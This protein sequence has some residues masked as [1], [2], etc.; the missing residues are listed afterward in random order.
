M[1]PLARF[2]IK[3]LDR[4]F[5]WSASEAWKRWRFWALNVVT[6]H[7]VVELRISV[8]AGGEAWKVHDYALG[9]WPRG[10][11]SLIPRDRGTD[12]RAPTLVSLGQ[13][14][15]TC[16]PDSLTALFDRIAGCRA[17][18]EVPGSGCY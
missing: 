3:G 6:A 8:I 11:S 13:A 15:T 16:P 10:G 14:D 2:R 9:G 18:L 5:A 7:T 1:V 4:S 17:L 12:L